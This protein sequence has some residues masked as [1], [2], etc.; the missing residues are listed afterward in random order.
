MTNIVKLNVSQTQAPLPST[1]QQ[2][3]A[4]VSQGGTTLTSGNRAYLTQLSDLTPLI[5]PSTLAIASISISGLTGTIT[6][7]APHGI[8]IGGFVPVALMGLTPAGYNGTYF[9]TSTGA[10][11][12]TVYFG[13][14]LGPVTTPGFYLSAEA[15]AYEIVQMATTFFAQGN[16]IG[17]YVFEVG[18]GSQANGVSVLST[19]ITNNPGTTYLWLVPREWAGEPTF[20]QYVATQEAN[21][22]K[23]YFLTTMTQGNAA[24]FIP[25]MKCVLGLVETTGVGAIEFNEFSLAA[26]MYVMLSYAPSANNRVTPL[27]F[28]FVTDAT[29]YPLFGN[30]PVLAT[31]KG[32]NINVIGTGAEG[33]I[34]N[35]LVAYG[36]TMDGRD[37]IYWY[38]VDW[39]EINVKLDL[40]NEV[41]NGS[42]NPQNP[43][44]YDQAGIDRLRV[45][46]QATMNRAIQFG[47]AIGPITV[48]AVA[49]NTYVTANPSDFRTGT[50]N[51]LA[52]TYTPNRGFE[53]ITFNV[54]VTDFPVAA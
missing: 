32:D 53:S 38:S 12:L 27:A 54:N 24:T 7:A 44:Y 1:L 50:Y 28:S 51:G 5:E 45:R 13:V 21:T 39:V 52:V 36:T 2:T 11:T 19:F 37:F 46:A 14:Y 6:T 31:L 33:G 4:L 43:L 9:V 49:F 22:A 48:T 35:A 8:G 10:S 29:P 25:T 15:E 23:V 42:N 16:A 17:V 41:I 47:L 34:T 26:V 40:A 30:G 20:V 18:A 3:G